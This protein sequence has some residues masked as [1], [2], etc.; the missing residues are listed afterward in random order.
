MLAG[1]VRRHR[2]AL[3]GAILRIINKNI[4]IFAYGNTDNMNTTKITIAVDGYSSTGKSTFARTAAAMLGYLYLDSGAMYRSVTLYG[5]DNR[6]VG[7]DGIDTA[8]L[9]ESL[10]GLDISFGNDGHGRFRTF[11]SGRDV[12]DRIRS[13]EVSTY[14]SRVAEL[15]FVRQFVDRILQDYGKGKGIVMDG[16]DIGTTVFPDAELK[17]F[18]TADKEVRARRRIKEMEESGKKISFEEVL[19]NIEQ[20]DFTDTHRKTSPLSMAKDAIVLDNSHMTLEQ[21]IDWLR[22]I[23]LERFGI[24][25]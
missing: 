11:I 7:P 9:K 25:I 3:G 19:A 4:I 14:V 16:R 15:P 12:E 23:L 22:R 18:M 17:I 13:F 8:G 2:E 5:I 20:R 10:P 24:C 6:H 1:T 21:E